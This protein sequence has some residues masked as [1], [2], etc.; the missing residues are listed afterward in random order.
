MSDD[1]KIMTTIRK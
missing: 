1:V